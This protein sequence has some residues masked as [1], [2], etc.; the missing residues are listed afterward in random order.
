MGAQEIGRIL[1]TADTAGGVWSFA[2]ELAGGLIGLGLDVCLASFGPHV[3]DSQKRAAGNIRDLQWLHYHSK[4][5]WMQE[6]WN[7]IES[8]GCWL[9]DVARRYRPDVVH[10]NTL[11]HGGLPWTAPV[12]STVHSCVDAWWLAVKK[13]PLP[14]EWNRYRH[15]VKFSLASSAL[16]TA[17]SRAALADV[18]RFYDVD[19]SNGQVI[20]NG[21]DSTHFRSVPKQ[22]FILS[23]GRL[24]DEAK[25]LRLLAG[26]A[27]ALQWPVFLA[28][29]TRNPSGEVSEFAGCHLLGE[30]TTPEL[31]S[32]YARASIYALPARYEPFGLSVLEAALSGCALVLGDIPSLREIWQD[33]A[34][35]VSPDDPEHLVATL[36]RLINDPEYCQNMSARALHRAVQFTPSRMVASYVSAYEAALAKPRRLAR[37]YA[38]AS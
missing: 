10:L 31:S 35:F 28:G 1:L 2:L 16:I 7:D 9:M 8:A 38:C 24:W 12:V 3:P 26:E 17:P 19:A 5:E 25:N 21:R 14:S 13:A 30:L 37:R 36:T 23:A 6:P 32:W 33:S 34:S 20:Y 27:S 4:L 11:C 15:E 18:E 29:D 22:P